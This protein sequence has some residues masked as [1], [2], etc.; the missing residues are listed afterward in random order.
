MCWIL[1]EIYVSLLNCFYII[2]FDSDFICLPLSINDWQ[3]T[4]WKAAGEKAPESA[5]IEATN[6]GKSMG[7]SG[8]DTSQAART[9]ACRKADA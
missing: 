2:L 1:V 8:V 5:A 3:S 4:S 7:M 6:I 9:V